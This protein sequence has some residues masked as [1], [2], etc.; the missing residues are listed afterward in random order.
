[1]KRLNI[2]IVFKACVQSKEHCKSI[3]NNNSGYIKKKNWKICVFLHQVNCGFIR[4]TTHVSGRRM[5][6]SKEAITKI[7]RHTFELNTS[8]QGKSMANKISAVYV[9]NCKWNYTWS[10]LT[11]NLSSK[12]D[13]QRPSIKTVVCNVWVYSQILQTRIQKTQI[14]PPV[15]WFWPTNSV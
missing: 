8:D 13:V 12:N 5:K 1:M 14:G 3:E 15:Q 11:R 4:P 10:I 9:N 6:G 7:G 2:I